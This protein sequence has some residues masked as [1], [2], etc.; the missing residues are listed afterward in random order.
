MED[1]EKRE[2]KGG[3]E[4]KEERFRRVLNYLIGNV[5]F[6]SSSFFFLG[7]VI[8]KVRCSTST[9]DILRKEQ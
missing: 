8:V 1:V 6:V 5:S 3:G 4:G 2:R 7:S 9:W